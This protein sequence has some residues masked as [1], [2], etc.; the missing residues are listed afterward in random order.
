MKFFYRKHLNENY[1]RCDED[2]DD[3]DNSSNTMSREKSVTIILPS[4]AQTRAEWE[5]PP[6]EHSQMLP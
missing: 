3:D 4:A 2:D 5:H 1:K 6:S